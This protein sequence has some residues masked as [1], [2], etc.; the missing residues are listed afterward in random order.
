[1]KVVAVADIAE[2]IR[3]V[4]Y[5]KADASNTASSGLSAVLRAGNIDDGTIVTS[6]LV[7]VP[8]ERVSDVQRLRMGDVLVATSSGS[9]DVVGK[10][11]MVKT[12]DAAGLGFGAF[13]KVLRPGDRI[14]PAYFGHFFQTEDYRRHV[15]RR[16]AGANINNLKNGDLDEIRIPLPPLDEQRRIAAILDAAD[17]LRTKRRQALSKLDTLTRAIFIDMFGDPATNPKGWPDR[18]IGEALEFLTYGHRF[19]D[20]S[21]SDYGTPVV[22]ITDLD[23]NGDLSFSDMP[24]MGLRE[25]ELRKYRLEAGDIL[26]ARSGATV[27]KVAL[28]RDEYPECIA[29]AYFIWMRFIKE[30]RPEYVRCVLTSD[31]IREIVSTKSR[32]AAQQNFSGPAIRRLPMPQ[33]PAELQIEFE[34]RVGTIR[35]IASQH[36]RS[37]DDL[38]RLFASLQQRAF[39]GEL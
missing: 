7:F 37:L 33:P 21:Y 24:R 6:D 15:R 23:E 38:D 26:F 12:H 5:K 27:G 3:G 31:R 32:Q 1:M 35:R 20:E 13:C 34:R 14:H 36:R 4:S 19:Y 16:A 29:G 17:A 2:Q 25:S 9:L 22:R 39:K 18:A 8:N 30:L 11:A 10:A 28:I